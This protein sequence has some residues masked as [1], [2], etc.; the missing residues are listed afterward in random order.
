M[1]LIPNR[2]LITDS[3]LRNRE[4]HTKFRYLMQNIKNIKKYKLLRVGITHLTILGNFL[5]CDR[6]FIEIWLSSMI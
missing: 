2:D 5:S 4:S 1:I 3:F 6:I